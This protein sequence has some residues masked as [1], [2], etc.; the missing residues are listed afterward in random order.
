VV[1]YPKNKLEEVNSWVYENINNGVYNCGFAKT[2]TA[3]EKAYY[4]LF[5]HLDKAEEILNK[6]RYLTG[7]Q[8][9]LADVRL[10]T[11]LFRFDPVYV[12]H[13]KCNKKRIIDF[14]NLWEFTKEIYQMS[15]IAETCNLEHIK[16]H[17]F[18]SHKQINPLGIVPLGPLIDYTQPH[19]RGEK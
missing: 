19:K 7:D 17:Y 18:M 11:T 15:G 1:T 9:T 4:N 16:K 12:V 14:P 2:Q 3:Y 8:F 5:D 13:F 10:F 6:N